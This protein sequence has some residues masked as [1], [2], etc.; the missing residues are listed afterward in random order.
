MST[1]FYK[2]QTGPKLLASFSHHT[3]KHSKRVEVWTCSCIVNQFG[4]NQKESLCSVLINPSNPELSGVSNFP[5]FPRGGPV[6]E[7]KPKSMHKD[8]QPLGYVSNWGGMEV[9]NGMLYP[10]S[11]VDGLVHQLGGAKLAFE[12][13]MI[14]IFK[15]GCPVGT[16]VETSPGGEELGKLYDLIIHCTP[17]FFRYHDNPVGALRQCYKSSF[18]AAFMN[19]RKQGEEC[20][21]AFPL[22]GAGARGFPIDIATNVAADE[23]FDWLKDGNR[24]KGENCEKAVVAFGI[25]D[26]EIAKLLVKEM[27]TLTNEG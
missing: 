3:T 5:Y 25:P 2:L 14:Q 26:P 19:N 1:A 24:S 27:T 10:V 12:C 18:D 4:K 22:I 23:C 21:A 17:P 15:G 11:V 16:A 20:R 13:K 8:W 6:P 9:G 7:E